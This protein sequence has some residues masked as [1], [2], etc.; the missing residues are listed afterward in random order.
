MDINAISYVV[1]AIKE[2]TC[3]RRRGSALARMHERGDCPADYARSHLSFTL[4]VIHPANNVIR[5]LKFF[6]AC[7]P[8]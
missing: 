6:L 5:F 4:H 3:D 7:I 2:E 1:N 8:C